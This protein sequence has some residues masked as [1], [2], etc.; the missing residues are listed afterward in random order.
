MSRGGRRDGA[1]APLMLGMGWFP[2]EAGGLNRYFRDLHAALGREGPAPAAVVVGPARDPAPGVV[3][4]SD[5]GRPLPLRLAG[6][7][8][9][10]R[11]AARA[12]AGLV[13]AHFALYALLPVRATGLRRWPL[14]VHFHGPW[15]GEGR[16]GGEPSA[17][18]AA[19]RSIERAVY[20]RADR[21]VV[22][23]GAFRRVLVER[24]GVAPWRIEVIPPGIDL[25][26]FTPGDGAERGRLGV[27][28]GT[29][30]AVATRRLVPRM[31]IDVLLRAWAEEDRGDRLLTIVGDGPLRRELEELAASLGI[32]GSV[33]F[34]GRVDDATLRDWY[35]A[36]DVCVV[37]SVALEGFGLVV[38]E[39]L[40]CGTP[41]VVSDVGGMPEA[42]AGLPGSPVV[43]EGDHRA[44][45]RRLAAARDGSAPLPRPA[46]C[47]AHAER[48]SWDR[49]AARHRALH[50]ALVAP[51]RRRRPR[52][53]LLDHCARLSGGEIAM[54]RTAGA[55]RAVDAH[56]VLAE[57]GPLVGRLTGA[58]VSVEVLPMAE[59]ARG[60][61]RDR[62]TAG[63]LPIAAA[64]ASSA[65]V[66]A[67]ARR[68]RRLRPDLVVTNSL[69][70]AL[71]GGLAARAAGIPVV[72]HVRDRL[73]ADYLPRQTVRLVHAAARVLP[74]GI[75]VN[76]EATRATLPPVR[77]PVEV[78]P[79]PVP[80]RPG[81][82]PGRARPAGP[83]TVGLVGRIAPWKGQDLFLDAFARAFPAGE[84]RAVLVGAPL[85]GEQDY[86]RRLEREVGR[87]GLDGRVEFRGFREDV[88]SELERLDVLV[89]SSTI[90]EP[91]GLV[92]LEGL[93][94][95]LPVVA[96]DIGGPAE[97][98]DD[99]SNGLLFRAGDPDALAGA[100]RR[101][102]DEP[103]LR[104]NLAAR[105]PDS[106]SGYRPADVAA[107]SERFYER[108]LTGRPR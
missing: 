6:F 31:G 106:V 33:R 74:H 26:R 38:L 22:L 7:D 32:A 19:K 102:R 4:A 48:F 69:K 43:P 67:L 25:D 90:P 40:A 60:L 21:F 9:A 94:A 76:S 11:R 84:E 20:R 95:G 52:V 23:S 45:A 28:P 101:L 5:R 92:V 3:V 56:V 39:A 15:A 13:D 24:Y 54:A 61:S 64:L 89:H 16:A 30:L 79:S 66:A 87:L 17:V 107:R 14:L 63:R 46:A 2:D 57:D 105:G 85:F 100:L 36:A 73:A 49:A 97:T 51:A 75:I 34:A 27:E 86:A 70:A 65:H 10:A 71:Y 53:V 82:G 8:L 37:P 18:V 72:W 50:A 29:W 59:G 78:I 62:V 68:L 104:A 58:G 55:L 77:C 88:A 1:P 47:R 93:A 98:I 81:P 44:L 12:G 103:A 96:P 91:L 99:G 42:V 35:R 80:D 41:V 108:V 83:L